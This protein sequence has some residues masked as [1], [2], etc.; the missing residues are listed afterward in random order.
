MSS[1]SQ[2]SSGRISSSTLALLESSVI[3]INSEMKIEA[4]MARKMIPSRMQ[5]APTILPA[6]V[7]GDMSPYP[8]VVTVITAGQKL[9]MMLSKSESGSATSQK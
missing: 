6:V 1:I 3:R 2:I 5:N 9:A 7:A 4:G 8:T